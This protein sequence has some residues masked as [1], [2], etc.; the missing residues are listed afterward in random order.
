MDFS[1]IDLLQANLLSPMV[2]AFALG[3]V[4]V[5]LKSDLRFPE[6]VYTILSIY[7]LLAIGMKGG[8]TLSQSSFSVIFPGL[9][10]TLA[11]GAVVPL[12]AFSFMRVMKYSRIDAAALAAHFGS[13]SVITFI[14][15][16]VFVEAVGY[17]F[18]K[19]LT[20][21][22]AILE[23]PAIIIGLLLARKKTVH[24]LWMEIKNIVV[25][26]SVLLLIG[27]LLI[28]YFSG[29]KGLERIAPLF[30]EPFQ[31]MLVLF[32]L[33]MGLVAGQKLKEAGRIHPSL[34]VAGTVIPL[35]NGVIGAV[36]A[37]LCGMDIGTATVFAC[38]AASASYIAAP[39]AVRMAL[40]QANPG[41]YLTTSLAITFPFNL[42]IG[43]PLYHKIVLWMM[44]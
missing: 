9:L 44:G 30:V 32:L 16:Q 41:Y 17:S 1:I 37:K 6:P 7:L 22:V 18:E 34:I 35:I 5:F 29:P 43:I 40:P 11:L 39:A 14:A 33:E 27:G 31:G 8:V 4:A 26:K 24:P 28:G 2:L 10:A 21:L 19:Y 36:L 23:V 12:L 38:I 42:S 3:V 25:S 15:S 13:V 20:A